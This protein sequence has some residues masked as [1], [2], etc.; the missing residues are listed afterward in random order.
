MQYKHGYL[1]NEQ[2]LVSSILVIL[3]LELEFIKVSGYQLLSIYFPINNL[4]YALRSSKLV[5][6]YSP[7]NMGKLHTQKCKINTFF[8]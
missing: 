3:F 6:L 5:D 4:N 1:L 2:G 7:F 8:L